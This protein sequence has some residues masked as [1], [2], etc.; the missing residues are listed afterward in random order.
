MT[1]RTPTVAKRQLNELKERTIDPFF[2]FVDSFLH[3]VLNND[4]G[5]ITDL[6]N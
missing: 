3:A 4:Q 1:E 6:P 2:Q 5:L